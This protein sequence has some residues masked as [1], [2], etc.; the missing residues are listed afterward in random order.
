MRSKDEKDVILMRP[1]EEGDL[2]IIMKWR[3]K[4][5]VTDYLYTDPKLTLETQKKWFKDISVNKKVKYWLVEF[6][7]VKIGLVWLQNIDEKNK[8]TE[9]GWFSG[10]L[11][12]R[13]KG[14]FKRVLVGLYEYVFEKISFNKIYCE[15][16][17]SNYYVIQN[18]YL[19]CG[20]KIEG[21]LREHIIKQNQAN[22]V[23]R[24]G[25]IKSDWNNIKESIEYKNYKL[26][27][28]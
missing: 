6:N 19:K 4:P 17:T 3:M 26:I 13:G 16:F 18:I 25:L 12:Y 2:E 10:E 27:V 15:V 1:V 22:D 5:E 11:D 21:F 8:T 24:M 14:I 28:E 7:G 23:L 9:F 20:L